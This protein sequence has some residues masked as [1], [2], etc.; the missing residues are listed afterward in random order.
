MSSAFSALWM[1][2]KSGHHPHPLGYLSANFCF[3]RGLHC[4]ASPRRK[5]EYSITLSINHPAYLMSRE[6]KLLLRRKSY[7]SSYCAF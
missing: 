1:Y 3:I 5:I 7:I 2:S 6:P 4:W